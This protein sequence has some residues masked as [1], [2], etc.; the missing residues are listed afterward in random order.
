MSRLELFIAFR[1]LRAKRKGIFAAITT[2]IGVAGVTVGVAALITTLSVMNGFQADIEKKIIGAQAD[3]TVYGAWSRADLDKTLAVIRGDKDVAA[4]APFV[5]GQ[6]IVTYQGRTSGIVIKGIDPKEEFMVNGLDRR[7]REGDWAALKGTKKEPGL[8]LGQELA[9]GLGAWTGER[10]VLVSPQGMATAMGLIPKMRRFR[11]AGLVHTGYYEYDS[12]MG[13]ASLGVAAKFF[14]VKSGATGVGVRVKRLDE[15]DTVAARLSRELGPDHP[16]RTYSQ[17]NE[18]LFAAL[19]LE[20]T[21]MFLILALI[22]LVASLNIA[23]TLI[24]RGVEKTRDMGLLM[25]MGA[26][27]RQIRAIFLAEGAMIG[28]VGLGLGLALGLTLCW[29]IKTFPIVKLPADIYYLSQVPVSVQGSDVAA[30]MILGFLL[31]LLATVYPAWRA[32]KIDPVEAIH[33]G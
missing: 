4:A 33:Y 29:V 26:T 9:R 31:A 22:V 7:L 23:S 30:V 25:A 13:F 16:V 8:V 1:Y 3:L 18:T 32:S 2:A 14:G 21:V 19:K 27:P 5:L 10:V 20:K 6:A 15:A 17:M 11:V 12:S 24:L 28:A